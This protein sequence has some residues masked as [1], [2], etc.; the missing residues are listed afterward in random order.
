MAVS[1]KRW[2]A[3]GEKIEIVSYILIHSMVPKMNKKKADD[4][5]LRYSPNKYYLL[6]GP[7]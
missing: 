3:F 7:Q 1:D 4:F 6:V 2:K 5:T